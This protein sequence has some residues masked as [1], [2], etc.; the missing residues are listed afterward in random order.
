[1]KASNTHFLVP[2][3]PSDAEKEA[4]RARDEN[5][6]GVAVQPPHGD[7]SQ[8]SDYRVV[9]SLSRDAML[10]L[11]SSMIRA[12]M[13]GEASQRVWEFE[14]ATPDHSAEVLGVYLHPRSARLVVS[15]VQGVALHELLKADSA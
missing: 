4:F 15:M 3:F 14:N 5:V 8:S 13:L 10:G 2:I 11:G 1:M 6:I 9:I 12:A 7:V